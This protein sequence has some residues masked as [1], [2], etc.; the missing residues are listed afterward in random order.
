MESFVLDP[1]FSTVTSI[2]LIFGSYEI[3]KYFL[4]KFN[5]DNH[6]SKVSILE[7]QYCTI[8]LVI[9]LILLFPLTAFTNHSSII[10]KVTGFI[11]IILGLKFFFYSKNLLKKFKIIFK[12]DKKDVL[13]YLY[14]LVI[15][16]YFL[17]ALSPL[18]SADVL[19]YH[20]GVALNIL[21]F[22]KY[23][24]LPEWFTG[25]QA[26]IGEV[27]IS[28]GFAAG[29]EQFGSLVQFTSIISIS[30]LLLKIFEKKKLIFLK[31]FNYFNYFIMS[32]F[33]FFTEW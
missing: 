23:V 21:R 19:D 9:L 3:G 20:A 25:L 11:L 5:I 10:L 18:T 17:L 6:L 12:K 33:N 13:F 16:L 1:I 28:L 7:F 2:L 8:G 14:I 15:F 32:Y 26:G 4:K 29:S 30:G 22:D 31:V 24:L 27:L